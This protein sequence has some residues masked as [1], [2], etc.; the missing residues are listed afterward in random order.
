[1]SHF[2]SISVNVL[3]FHFISGYGTSHLLTYREPTLK[4]PDF[5]MNCPDFGDVLKV[6]FPA[7]LGPGVNSASN[8]NEHQEQTNNHVFG[9]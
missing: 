6:D 5:I 2:L 7:V 9:E 1:M 8:R 3:V 4:R